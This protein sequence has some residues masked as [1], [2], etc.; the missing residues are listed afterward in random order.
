MHFFAYRKEIFQMG[1]NNKG[2]DFQKSRQNMLLRYKIWLSSVSGDGIIN[3]TQWALLMTID[4]TESLKTAAEENNISYRKAWGDLKKTEATLGYAL[5][6]KFR[7]GKSGGKTILTDKARK[8]LEAYK[9]LQI[10]FDESIEK[11]FADFQ[12]KIAANEGK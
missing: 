10:Q 11:A 3:D 4:R 6:Q 12:K 7:G 8:L 9:A 5:T 1:E 2:K